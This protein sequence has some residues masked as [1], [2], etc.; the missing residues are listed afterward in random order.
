MK[1]E[2]RKAAVAA[3]KERKIE[4]GV[5]AI[6]CR[7]SD[8]LWVGIALDLSTI[9]NRLWFEL[10][11]GSN[12]HRSLQD[13]WDAHGG[14]MFTLEVVERLTDDDDP[15]YSRAAALKRL[16]EKWIAKLNATRM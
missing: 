1:E 8:Q 2:Y 16:H 11:H 10:R 14:E 13:A 6:R 5:Y 3:Y 4:S 15:G 9:Q 7:S 12:S